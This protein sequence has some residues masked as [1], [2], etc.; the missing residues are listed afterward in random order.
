MKTAISI[1]DNVYNAAEQLAN[2]LGQSRSELYSRAVSNY[3]KKHQ[4]EKVTEQLNDIY[5]CEDSN[6]N[7]ALV[8]LQGQSTLKNN[9]W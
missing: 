1:P 6:L 7:P 5:S 2:R 4:N 9:P 3:I 8:L